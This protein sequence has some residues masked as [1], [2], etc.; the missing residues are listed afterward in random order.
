MNKCTV[1]L[2]NLSSVFM[3]SGKTWLLDFKPINTI[4]L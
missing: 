4:V 3:R 1:M 2:Q